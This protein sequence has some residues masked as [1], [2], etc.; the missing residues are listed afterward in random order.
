MNSFLMA[1]RVNFSN[2]ASTKGEQEGSASR[3]VV[4]RYAV[5]MAYPRQIQD[6]DPRHCLSGLAHP[7]ENM[8]QQ[9][10]KALITKEVEDAAQGNYASSGVEVLKSADFLSWLNDVVK[11]CKSKPQWRWFRVS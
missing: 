10:E 2:V 3:I 6:T 8:V 4:Q 1:E 7:T 11:A 5:T 9:M